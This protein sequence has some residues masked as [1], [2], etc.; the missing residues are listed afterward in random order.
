MYTGRTYSSP[1]R[2]Q[3]QPSHLE[4][5]NLLPQKR[6]TKTCLAN[7]PVKLAPAMMAA[8]RCRRAASRSRG[9]RRR[10]RPGRCLPGGAAILSPKSSPPTRKRRDSLMV[11]K[12]NPK[13]NRVDVCLAGTIKEA[14][15]LHGVVNEVAV[16]R[17]RSSAASSVCSFKT[18]SMA[19]K[20]TAEPSLV[21]GWCNGTQKIAKH[22]FNKVTKSRYKHKAARAEEFQCF[23]SISLRVCGFTQSELIASEK[24]VL[25]ESSTRLA[26]EQRR[27]RCRSWQTPVVDLCF[28]MTQNQLI[29]TEKCVLRESSTRLAPTQ[30]RPR[31]GSH[32]TTTRDF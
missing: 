13:I 26:S 10:P 1:A 30:R 11:V 2:A 28:E 18:P 6:Y 29:A 19:L 8:Q 21:T 20:S 15:A 7:L 23:L 4:E 9:R 16:Q 3:Q 25:C 14:P 22:V 31:C 5:Q 32:R 27:R 12:Q 17:P 24:C